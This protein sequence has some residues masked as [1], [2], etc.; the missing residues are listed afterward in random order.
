MT[1]GR[2]KIYENKRIMINMAVDEKHLQ[3][4]DEIANSKK[5][6]RTELITILLKNADTEEALR[7]ATAIGELRKQVASLEKANKELFEKYKND[8]I[9]AE[10]RILSNNY[11][12]LIEPDQ[13]SKEA[14]KDLQPTLETIMVMRKGAIPS[15]TYDYWVDEALKILKDNSLKEGRVVKDDKKAKLMLR[16]LLVEFVDKKTGEKKNDRK[17]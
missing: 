15:N 14:F 2:P 8:I 17:R 16:R 10:S 1:A 11:D 9:K 13:L 4:L 12:D 6:S 7:L 3:H 5:I